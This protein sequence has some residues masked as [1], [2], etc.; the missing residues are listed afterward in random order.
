VVY[1]AAERGRLA[2]RDWEIGDEIRLC[3]PHASDV[4]RASLSHEFD[5]L[6]GWLQLDAI[7]EPDPCDEWRCYLYYRRRSNILDLKETRLSWG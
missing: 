6:P 3:P 2:N 5:T 4:V 7:P 1:H